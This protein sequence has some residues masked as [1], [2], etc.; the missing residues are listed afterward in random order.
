LHGDDLLAWGLL[1]L[2]RRI[3]PSKPPVFPRRDSG[4]ERDMERKE[5]AE[6]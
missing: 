6:V 1:A 5:S 2:D 3:R 4:Y